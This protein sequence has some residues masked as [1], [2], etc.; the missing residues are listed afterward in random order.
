MSLA[1]V[2]PTP[3]F[4]ATLETSKHA[5]FM[6]GAFIVSLIPLMVTYNRL[7]R[8]PCCRE[9]ALLAPLQTEM[10]SVA[11]ALLNV[12]PLPIF[13]ITRRNGAMSA[14]DRQASIQ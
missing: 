12:F 4:V 10:N 3:S 5:I 2:S 14:S 11:I 9:Q 13:A 1:A 6:Y 7:S 8:S